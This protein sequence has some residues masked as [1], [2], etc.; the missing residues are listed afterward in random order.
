MLT[1]E[2]RAELVAAGNIGREA[3]SRCNVL[4]GNFVLPNS[5]TACQKNTRRRAEKRVHTGKWS[6]LGPAD[7]IL[8]VEWVMQ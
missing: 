5:Q 6:T 7:R 1:G 8:D 4:M 3:L 2:G